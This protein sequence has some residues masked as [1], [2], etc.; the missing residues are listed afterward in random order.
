MSSREQNNTLP[1]DRWSHVAGVYDGQQLALYINGKQVDATLGQGKRRRNRLP[2]FIGADPD[3][4]G[5]PSR[6]YS[7]RIDEFR[8]SKTARYS[9]DFVPEKRF[10]P[11]GDTVLLIHMDQ[12]VGPFVLDHSSSAAHAILG[13]DSTFSDVESPD[14]APEIVGQA[15]AWQMNPSIGTGSPGQGLAYTDSATLTAV[16]KACGRNHPAYP[17]K[18]EMRFFGAVNSSTDGV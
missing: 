14:C 11:D 7:G 9:G 3:G 1:T 13:A 16:A 15:S 17:A 10:E 12:S 2:L 8:L 18:R 5:Q 6:P 4:A